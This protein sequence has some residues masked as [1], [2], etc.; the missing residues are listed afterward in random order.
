M[1]NGE[2]NSHE[3]DIQLR[4]FSLLEKLINGMIPATTYY[5]ASHLF[6]GFPD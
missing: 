6:E 5:N 1:G 3:F 4:R 2:S